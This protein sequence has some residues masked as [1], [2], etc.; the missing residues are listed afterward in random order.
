[1]KNLSLLLIFAILA[2]GVTFT[3]CNKYEEGPAFAFL[4]AKTRVVRTWEVD[5]YVAAD[6]TETAGDDT[7][8][9][10][11]FTKDG[12]VTITTGIIAATGTWL[13][14]SENENITV[15]YSYSLLGVDVTSEDDF[16][17]IR[18][19]TKEF[20]LEDADEDQIHLKAK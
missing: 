10:Y 11:N 18:L 1:M 15:T 4:P 12:E 7:D 13:L 19:T 20:W 8:P 14:D 17:I 5:K 2:S 9:T 16:K 3:S 6:G